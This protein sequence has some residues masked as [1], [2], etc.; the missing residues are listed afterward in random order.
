[1]LNGSGPSRQVSWQQ[2]ALLA[3]LALSGVAMAWA[4]AWGV[5]G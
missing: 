4:C 1:M 2:V 5:R 3:V